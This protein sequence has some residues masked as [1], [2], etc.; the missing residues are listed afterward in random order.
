MLAVAR[1]IVAKPR[2][3]VVD[4]MSLGLAPLVVKRLIGMLRT[5][6]DTTGAAVLFVEQYVDLALQIADRALV[7]QHGRLVMEGPA[8]ELR[9]RRDML[10]TS[11]LGEAVEL[12]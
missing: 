8:A 4:E 6:A 7:M 5:I 11:Y 9:E 1:A 3:L 2:L 10:A 12:D